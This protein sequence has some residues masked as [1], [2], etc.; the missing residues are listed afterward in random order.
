MGLFHSLT[1]TPSIGTIF[2][3]ALSTSL[4]A[5]ILVARPLQR[6]LEDEST[7]KQNG[8]SYAKPHPIPMCKG[9][10]ADKGCGETSE[11]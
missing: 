10:C 8:H 3:L 11:Q 7:D 9:K 4:V 1:T 5:K 6:V 2:C